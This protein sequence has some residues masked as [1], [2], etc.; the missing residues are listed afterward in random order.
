MVYMQERVKVKN[1]SIMLQG[2]LK[3]VSGLKSKFIK[4]PVKTMTDFDTQYA[5]PG[6][7]LNTALQDQI[8][9]K[10]SNENSQSQ[11]YQSDEDIKAGGEGGALSGMKDVLTEIAYD[12]KSIAIN[13]LDTS[14]ILRTA[15]EPGRDS[16]IA[17]A[18][19]EDKEEEGKDEGGGKFDFKKLIP[20]PGPK[21][22]LLLMLGAL[23]ALFKYSDQITAGIAKVLPFVTKFTDM[24]GPKGTLFLGLGLL[25]GILFPGP[26]YL[27]LGA[28]K[29][30]IKIAF[31]LLKT[32]FTLMQ[33]FLMSTPSLLASTYSGV[34]KAFAFLG[35]AFT[36]LRLFMVGTL[37][38]A[39]TAFFAPILPA[40][41]P[42]V[43]AVAA[44]T[45]IFYSIKEG[46]D[47]FR[48]SLADGDSMLVAITKGVSTAL[49]TLITLPITLIQKAAVFLADKFGGKHMTDTFRD[50]DIVEFITDGVVGLV[51][52]AKD[53][54]LGLF[55][56]DFQA[57]LGKFVDIGKSIMVSI[58]AIGAGAIAAAKGF[59]TP[60]KSF[61][62]GY[63]EYIK[64]NRIPEPKES[65]MTQDDVLEISSDESLQK[66]KSI[67]R[68][69]LENSLDNQEKID[70]VFGRNS[71]E[72]KQEVMR[73]H[74]I[75]KK[76]SEVE[77]EQR[78]REETGSI[79]TI[80]QNNSQN[81][82][83][84]NVES[85]QSSGLSAYE[86][87]P[88]ARTLSYFRN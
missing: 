34:G 21:V 83:S 16:K 78:K 18:G 59:L 13:T 30:S 28:G 6:P 67:L 69:G 62:K 74:A 87:D 33:T 17:G 80:V 50:F 84:Q 46:I 61:K 15:F 65:L 41:L 1:S 3:S 68:K 63:D 22:G 45:A 72:Y 47:K 7:S 79:T 66:N 23:T 25:A 39:I 32:G 37:A 55:D 64:N 24:L 9:S 35:K 31:G 49:L 52:K 36:A 53:F 58:K 44:A 11:Y 56:I 10:T 71:P 82:N 57:V 29:G 60:V 12:I 73:F 42:V 14:D 86:N 70:N 81:D 8:E 75:D 76:L 88:S 19:V 38:P 51:L 85:I 20:K 2:I 26:L 40:I 5:D 54:V 77:K 4:S 48:E 27:L 43:L